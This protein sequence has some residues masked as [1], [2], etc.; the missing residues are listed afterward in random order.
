MCGSDPVR[1]NY[2]RYELW[3]PI[4]VVAASIACSNPALA[5]D[6]AQEELIRCSIINLLASPESYDG[7]R[8]QVIGYARIRFEGNALFLSEESAK[9]EVVENS[10]WL[11]FSGW[12]GD[13][14]ALAKRGNRYA[15]VIGTFSQSETG[16]LGGWFGGITAIER[17][18]PWPLQFEP[19]LP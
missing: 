4:L 2:G 7:K 8:I 5:G 19:A 12:P 14:Q 9:H 3:A 13:R 16:H 15:I 1:I 10:V 18:D 6:S 17:F 11:D